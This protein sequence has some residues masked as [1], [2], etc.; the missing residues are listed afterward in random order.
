MN[1]QGTPDVQELE[2]Q[3]GERRRDAEEASLANL[4]T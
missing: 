4:T 2:V 3:A 1:V